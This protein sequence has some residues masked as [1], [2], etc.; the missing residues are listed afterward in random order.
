MLNAKNVLKHELIGLHAKVADS[1]NKDAIGIE[2]KIMM[3]T[4]NTLQIETR[5]GTKTV[6]KKGSKFE[7]VIPEGTVTV[8]GNKLAARPEDR[9]KARTKKW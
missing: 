2:G 8:D 7:L 9:V 5:D 3:E 1:T 6:Q 4:K